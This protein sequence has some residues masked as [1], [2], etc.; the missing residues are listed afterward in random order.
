MNVSLI[1]KCISFIAILSVMAQPWSSFGN[2]DLQ[3]GI[4]DANLTRRVNIPYLGVAPPAS[5]F[6]PAIFWFGDINYISNY[7]DVRTWYFDGF[8][9]FRRDFK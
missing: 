2:F 1:S 4:N 8:L 3:D 6:T 7:V 5:N 9:D